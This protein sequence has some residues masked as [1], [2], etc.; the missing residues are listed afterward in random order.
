MSLLPLEPED[1][2][3]D[4]GDFRIWL[5]QMV[6]VLQGRAE[7]DVP[8]QDCIGCCSSSYFIHVGPEDTE[9]LAVIPRLLL[10]QARGSEGHLMGFD[11]KGYCPMM[12]EGRCDIYPRRPR[13]CR[14]YDCRLFAAAGILAGDD[15]KRRINE[16]IRRWRFS[17]ARPEDLHAHEAI[18]AMADFLDEHKKSLGEEIVTDH[19][20]HIAM[21]ALRLHGLMQDQDQAQDYASLK[22]RICQ[23]LGIS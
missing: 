7:A 3:L 9:A 15:S 5:E 6:L 8:C 11:R 20:T 18:R 13:T 12:R 1:Q 22:D 4:A 16:R 14:T 10:R 2:S 23:E 19:P 17:Y 21:R